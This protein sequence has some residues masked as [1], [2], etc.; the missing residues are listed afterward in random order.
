MDAEIW[1]KTK[2]IAC[3]YCNLEYDLE[4]GTRGNRYDYA[5]FL[6]S[7]LFG[8]QDALVVN[9]NAVAV[10]LVLNTFAKD[11]K[12]IVSRGELVEIGDSFRIQM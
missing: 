1:D 2:Q 11:A 12:T 10:F 4:K 5:A 3:G 6:L 7:A 8:C 9:N